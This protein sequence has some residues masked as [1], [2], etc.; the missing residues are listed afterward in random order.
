MGK[1][2]I[3]K[4][5]MG[6]VRLPADALYGAQTRRAMDNF[7]VSNTPMPP[8]FI[9]AVARIKASAARVNRDLGLLEQDMADAIIAACQAIIVG[10]HADQFPVD[11]YQTGS[12][13]STNMNVNEV[14]AGIAGKQLGRAVHPN[15]HVN[16]GQSSNDVIPT[17]I[18]VSCA[19]AVRDNLLPALEHLQ[20][21]IEEKARGLEDCV[22]TGRTHLMDAVPLTMSQELSA[23]AGQVRQQQEWLQQGLEALCALAQGGTAVGTGINTHAEFARRFAEDL[24]A[25]TG[26]PFRPAANLFTAIS[27]QDTAV[28]FSGQLKSLAVALSKIANDLRWMNSGP[29]AGLAEIELE[30]LQPGSSIM[31]GKVNPVIA[32]A[33]L[34]AAARVM[35]NDTTVTIAG[36]AGNFQL[37]T[38]LPLIADVLLQDVELLSN[39]C[40]QLAD[41]AIANFEVIYD[42]I[43]RNL[44]RNPILATALNPYIGYTAA[45]KIARQAYEEQRPVI[46]V[47]AEQTDLT[48]EELE[49]ILDP[50]KLTRGGFAGKD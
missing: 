50:L 43:R 22:K 29:L 41:K 12:G 44:D 17:A 30:A 23:W 1:T 35:G 11:V 46:D 15:D 49:A 10:D 32:E 2:R 8:A 48:R 18:H 21:C 27:S 3:E 13:T 47:A 19:F 26:F 42:N 31:P 40:L 28:T 6:E 37:N 20:S 45:A 38:M 36:R 24:A 9:R 25:H 16:L 33:V 34:M 14:V 4:D 7:S 5:S 39:S